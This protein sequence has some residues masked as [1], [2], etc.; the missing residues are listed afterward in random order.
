[1]LTNFVSAAT[2]AAYFPTTPTPLKPTATPPKNG[3]SSEFTEIWNN[4]AEL[5]QTSQSASDSAEAT[6]PQAPGWSESEL[7]TLSQIVSQLE[8]QGTP[9][10]VEKALKPFLAALQSL[11][12]KGENLQPFLEAAKILT[13]FS[14]LE[15]FKSF[16][17]TL[18]NLLQKQS[19][20]DSPVSSHQVLLELSNAVQAIFAEKTQKKLAMQAWYW[21]HLQ[22]SLGDLDK[23]AQSKKA[24]TDESLTMRSLPKGVE[25]DLAQLVLSEK[26]AQK[27]SEHS[28]QILALLKK[29]HQTE[30]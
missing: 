25:I 2:T 27:S 19:S 13:T 23:K 30:I 1:M 9:A 18:Q 7:Q 16:T 22:W 28:S 6:D 21:F 17:Q 4:L 12:E 8:T 20:S 14:S 5:L 24:Q 11:K 26:A 15:E 29:P 10:Q 3:T